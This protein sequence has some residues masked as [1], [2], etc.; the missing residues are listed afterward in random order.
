MRNK[1][2]MT[3]LPVKKPD[4]F[5][6]INTLNSKNEVNTAHLRPRNTKQMLFGAENVEDLENIYDF[7]EK[8][9]DIPNIATTFSFKVF[10]IFFPYL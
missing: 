6:E 10:L 3:Q 8:Y 2:K 4:T 7:Q 1:L 5:E 9:G